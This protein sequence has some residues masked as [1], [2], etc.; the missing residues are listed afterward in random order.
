MIIET[1]TKSHP[2]VT[3]LCTNNFYWVINAAYGS[4]LKSGNLPKRFHTN[5][6]DQIKSNQDQIKMSLYVKNVVVITF[7]CPIIKVFHL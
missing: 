6:Q 7:I 4:N 2:M 5:N 1:K 3:Y